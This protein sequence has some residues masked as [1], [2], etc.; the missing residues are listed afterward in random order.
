MNL[1]ID[2][3]RS[4]V[5]IE[6]IDN[7]LVKD[8]IENFK[9]DEEWRVWDKRQCT[10]AK[11]GMDE[12][13]L[14][15]IRTIEKFNATMDFK[16]PFEVNDDTEFTRQDLNIVHRYFTTSTSYSSWTLDGPKLISPDSLMYPIFL[17]RATAINDAV[18][19]L[20][21]YY[22]TK[23][24]EQSQNVNILS[25]KPIAQAPMDYFQHMPGDWRYLDYDLEYDVFMNYAICGKDYFQAYIDD[26]DPRK[27][28][29]TAQY[30][31]YYNY[32]YIDVNGERNKIMSSPEFK[33][34]LNNA[35]MYNSAWQF[36][37]IGK[38]ISGRH[39]PASTFKGFRI[40]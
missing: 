16:F 8:W 19:F 23:N 38:V 11:E 18:H 1:I 36:M 29:I 34:W 20:E 32:F 22:N 37:P 40:E 21:N 31:S 33:L 17:K 39:G 6:L 2:Y 12:K 9:A 7:P 27:W 10:I 25:F 35:C 26:D 30:S 14:A 13:R 4:S 15:L 24:K 5:V 3:E 28:D